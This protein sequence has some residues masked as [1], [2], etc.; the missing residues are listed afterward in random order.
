MGWRYPCCDPVRLRLSDFVQLAAWK[1]GQNIICKLFSYS[2]L[3]FLCN[4]RLPMTIYHTPHFC[5]FFIWLATPTL[6]MSVG[7][8]VSQAQVSDLEV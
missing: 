2:A 6:Q 7:F 4:V 3:M 8:C 5:V 1:I